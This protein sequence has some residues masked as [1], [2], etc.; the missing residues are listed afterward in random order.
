MQGKEAAEGLG[1]VP[2]TLDQNAEFRALG[3]QSNI[4]SQ[5]DADRRRIEA[6]QAP[7]SFFARQPPQDYFT[8]GKIPAPVGRGMTWKSSEGKYFVDGNGD[9]KPDRIYQYRDGK[10]FV[11]YGDGNGPSVYDRRRY[12]PPPNR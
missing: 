5:W 11:D 9:G 6:S 8:D 10:A 4:Q 3:R 7:N 2:Q 1:D 12:Q